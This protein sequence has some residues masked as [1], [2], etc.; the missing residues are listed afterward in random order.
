MSNPGSSQFVVRLGDGDLGPDATVE[1]DV[2]VEMR[3]GLR[4]ACDVYR[5][6]AAGRYPVLYAV[7]PYIKDTVDLPTIS[8]YRYREIGNIVHWGREGVRVRPR[9]LPRGQTL[10]GR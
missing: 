1:R 8:V 9:R 3:D 5:P 4:I 7:S 10:R 6:V 2:M